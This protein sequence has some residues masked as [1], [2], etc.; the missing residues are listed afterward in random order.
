MIT[1]S[2]L[3]LREPLH[4]EISLNDEHFMETQYGNWMHNLI[5]IFYIMVSMRWNDLVHELQNQPNYSNLS[6][7]DRYGEICPSLWFNTLEC[8][9]PDI[10]VSN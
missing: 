6:R 9:W 8:L 1:L 3:S 4:M 10:F 2:Y 7:S 5:I